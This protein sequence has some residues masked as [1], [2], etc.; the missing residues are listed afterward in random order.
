M[1]VHDLKSDT[2]IARVQCVITALALT[3]TG[4]LLVVTNHSEILLTLLLRSC[5][6][7]AQLQNP[8][9]NPKHPPQSSWENQQEQP[10]R[11]SGTTWARTRT[12]RRC[13]DLC[14]S[15]LLSYIYITIV[16]V[17]N[18]YFCFYHFAV[19]RIFWYKHLHQ[20]DY[21]P[22]FRLN[23]VVPLVLVLYARVRTV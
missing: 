15:F 10:Q 3:V 2:C 8:T 11:E 14:C 23:R 13:V 16:S 17:K 19:P 18:A 4:T 22:I 7:C 12:R 5:L 9:Q 21:Y 1:A 6:R 20:F